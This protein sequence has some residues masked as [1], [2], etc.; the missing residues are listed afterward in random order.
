MFF[1]GGP[2]GSK[3]G[4]SGFGGCVGSNSPTETRGSSGVPSAVGGSAT[5]GGWSVGGDHQVTPETVV[6][7]GDVHVRVVSDSHTALTCAKWLVVVVVVGVVVRRP[8]L[9]VVVVNVVNI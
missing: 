3:S 9:R 1:L 5:V 4:G 7:P 8:C 6:S 2:E